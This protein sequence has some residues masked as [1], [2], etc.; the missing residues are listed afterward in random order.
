M[1]HQFVTNTRFRILAIWSGWG[2]WYAI[3]L[4]QNYITTNP[5][6][7]FRDRIIEYGM[8]GV[9]WALIT[10]LVFFLAKRIP[11][12][13]N[14]GRVF[15]LHFLIASG[16]LLIRSALMTFVFMQASR[17]G[18]LFFPTWRVLITNYL[19]GSYFLYA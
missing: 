10:P 8:L 12:E 11:Y 3:I 13:N 1:L 14:F 19:A 16:I 4:F 5:P 2:I 9:F 6:D 7:I 15:L 17:S 18:A